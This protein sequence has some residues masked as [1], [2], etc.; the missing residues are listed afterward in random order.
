MT[1]HRISSH[2]ARD[3]RTENALKQALARLEVGRPSHHDNI[4]AASRGRLRITF[5][6]VAREAGVSR[7]L[8][9]HEGCRYPGVRARIIEITQKNST[10][11]RSGVTS[12]ELIRNLRHE[13]A[14]LKRHMRVLATRL[15]DA[16]V[17]VMMI[18]KKLG[19]KR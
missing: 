14:E 10:V 4:A 3:I 18:E 8:I 11:S 5:T 7:T 6:S 16:A 9:A 2:A 19:P 17:K 1:Q 13:N 15:N 12:A